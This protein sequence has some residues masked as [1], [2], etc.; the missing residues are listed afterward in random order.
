MHSQSRG[1]GTRDLERDICMC[2]LI[3]PSLSQVEAYHT[4]VLDHAQ[5]D[6]DSDE[7]KCKNVVFQIEE[8]SLKGTGLGFLLACGFMPISA[9]VPG[10]SSNCESDEGE[11]KSVMFRVEE[12][13]ST[14]DPERIW[15]F[16]SHNIKRDCKSTFGITTST[17]PKN[18]SSQARWRKD[19]IV[20]VHL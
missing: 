18:F 3:L 15:C 19:G 16:L 13:L 20:S 10:P 6:C 9:M 5:S 12:L 1:S 14:A 8:L 2:C 4:L 7:E 11:C 17:K